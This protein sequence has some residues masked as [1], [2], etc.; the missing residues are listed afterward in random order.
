M[1]KT[2]LIVAA[3][4]LWKNR[5]SSFLNIAGLA[6]GITCAA[7]IFLWIENETGYD[8]QFEKRQ[9]VYRVIENQTYDGKLRT[10]YSTPGPLAEAMKS[11]IPGVVNAARVSS[12]EVLFTLNEKAI[13]QRGLYA[14]PAVA[15]IFSLQFLQGSAAN[16]FNE[17]HAVVI[18][19]KM[20]RQFFGADNNVIGKTLKV[21]NAEDFV[22][23]GV[24]KDLPENVTLKFDWLAGFDH[25][26][27]GK[28]FINKW[29]S[30][31]V[32][33]YVELSATAD[34]TAVNARLKGFI[35][36]MSGNKG[37]YAF[38][39]AM[40]DWHLRDQFEDGKQTGGLITYIRMFAVIAWIILVIA[41]INFMNLATAR[42]EKRAKEV[43]VRKVMGAVKSRLVLQFITE[44]VLMSALAV[45]IGTLL[46][47]LVLP[48]FNVLVERQLSAGLGNPI[49]LL[50]LAGIALICGLL[51][52][53]YP[54]FYLSSFKPVA[55]FKGLKEK[56]GGAAFIR[57]GLVVTQFAVSIILIISTVIIYQQVRHVQ[58]RDL[59]Y[60]KDHLLTMNVRGDIAKNF[61][62]IKQDMLNT[63]LVENVALNS[64]ETLSVGNNS[65]GATWP[66]KDESKDVLISNRIISPEFIATAGMK[67]TEGRDFRIDAPADSSNI[68]ITASLA[69]MMG[70]ES[71][72]GKSIRF[73][74]KDWQVVGIV[75]DFVY[76]DMYGSS[77]PV[78]FFYHTGKDARYLFIRPKAGA[79]TSDVL[80]KLEVVMKR[81]NAGYPF[82]YS[83]VDDLF[84]AK[85]K[86]EA[87]AGKL[88]RLFA[89]LAIV[90]SCFGLFGLAAY[91]AERRTREIGVRKVLGA[92]VAGITRLLA[93]DFL[94]L[95]II[96]ALIAFP[97]AWWAMNNW[98]QSYAYRIGINWWIFPLAATGALAIAMLTVSFQS[99][100]AALANPVKSLR[101]E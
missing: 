24:V 43:G 8:N 25:Y 33:T 79:Q 38:L 55:V 36:K 39:F 31:S 87:L 9:Q 90:I 17:T 61:K 32:A 37:T 78:M 84:A 3:R 21:E 7:L 18:S 47:L 27:K 76:G 1:L 14:D 29:G 68:L 67:I 64:F 99:V 72:I 20:A 34:V 83:F 80:A 15:Q 81:D 23:T 58:N 26:A 94:I 6:I 50:L 35:E 40:Q 71:A 28:D 16:A 13:Y 51:A 62:L 97:V 54:A 91:T 95:V 96:A 44:S 59:G 41:C 65:S 46:V 88:S 73:R 30:N 70:K 11:Q 52:G 42:S 2:Y 82:E 98:L 5:S 86:S 85:F 69:K 63:G 89:L 75:K 57:K 74:D 10:F 4:N 77:D 60:N 19:Q 48:Y 53:S 49:H 93:G 92:S 45:I 22:V 56:A 100:K 66:G 101:M 12:K